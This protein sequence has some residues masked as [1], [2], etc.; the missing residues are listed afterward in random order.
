MTCQMMKTTCLKVDSWDFMSICLEKILS[1]AWHKQS[2]NKFHVELFYLWISDP[3]T[4]NLTSWLTDLTWQREDL[5]SQNEYEWWQKNTTVPKALIFCFLL[6]FFPWIFFF[7]AL[8]NY[9]GTF[10]KF[11]H[12]FLFCDWGSLINFQMKTV[13]IYMISAKHIR[14]YMINEPPI[15]RVKWN[16]V[17]I[18][19]KKKPTLAP[20]C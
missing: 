13:F 18:T 12:S 8:S 16:K 5:T 11:F 10:P 2:I 9:H 7:F 19:L 14:D 6:D 4:K 1:T 3:S 15:S 20:G 17:P